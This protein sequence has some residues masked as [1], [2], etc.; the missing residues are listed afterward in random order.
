MSNA[1]TCTLLYIHVKDRASLSLLY[2]MERPSTHIEIL[3]GTDV[4]IFC[5][6]SGQLA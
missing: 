5:P 3:F 2:I 6:A 4:N 1:A